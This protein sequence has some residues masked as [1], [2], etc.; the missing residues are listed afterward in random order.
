METT[1]EQIKR[2][3][4]SRESWTTEQVRSEFKLSMGMSMQVMRSL[5]NDGV[6]SGY[7]DS[8]RR[9]WVMND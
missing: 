9:H 1:E 2:V 8:Y 6:L 3:I 5:I 4:R 7:C